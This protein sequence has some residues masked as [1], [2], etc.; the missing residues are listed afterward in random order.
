[1][2]FKCHP[3]ILLWC[4]PVSYFFQFCYYG[5]WIT[6][7]PGDMIYGILFLFFYFLGTEVADASC[8]QGIHMRLASV[9]QEDFNYSEY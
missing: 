9:L 1:M 8:L 4:Y 6:V 7:T 3:S 2:V 5:N